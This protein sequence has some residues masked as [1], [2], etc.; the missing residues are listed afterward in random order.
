MYE[1]LFF[2]SFYSLALANKLAAA[3]AVTP[4]HTALHTNI[5]AYIHTTR[6]DTSAILHDTTLY[7]TIL[8]DTHAVLY[9][10]SNFMFIYRA[11]NTVQRDGRVRVGAVYVLCTLRVLHAYVVCVCSR[12]CRHR[13]HHR[14][15]DL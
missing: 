1:T 7:D 14:R 10:V 15:S 9:R 4:V 3:V 13:R 2:L 6:H 12:C 8:Y 11:A 5:H